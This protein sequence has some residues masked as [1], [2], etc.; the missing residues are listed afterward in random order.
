MAPRFQEKQVI[1]GVGFGGGEV[2]GALAD[3]LSS[4]R[5]PLVQMGR[6]QT[7]RQA[8]ADA[9]ES[10]ITGD[11]T[12]REGTSLSS[13]TYNAIVLAGSVASTSNSV[14]KRLKELEIEHPSDPASYEAKAQAFIKE[15]LTQSDPSI[16]GGLALDF[17]AD[18]INGYSRVLKSHKAETKAAAMAEL[19]TAAGNA[20]NTASSAAF[21]GNSATVAY[22]REKVLTLASRLRSSGEGGKADALIGNFDSNIQKQEVYG[23]Y[24]KAME[25]GSGKAF[26]EEFIRRGKYPPEIKEKYVTEM[27]QRQ[28]RWD[29]LTKE[30]DNQYDSLIMVQGAIDGKMVLDPTDKGHQKAVDTHWQSYAQ[31]LP[32]DPVSA[33]EASSAYITSIGIIP[34][35]IKNL[36]RGAENTQDPKFASMASDIVARINQK[37]PQ[38]L[39]GL[40]NKLPFLLSMNKYKQTGLSVDESFTMA[41]EMTNPDKRAT[42]DFRIEEAKQT[43]EEHELWITESF[44]TVFSFEKDLDPEQKATALQRYGDLYDYWYA[45]TGDEDIAKEQSLNDFAQ[46]YGPT[47]FNDGVVM[48]YPPENYY[49]YDD[50]EW[51]YDQFKSE[52][53]KN[54]ILGV[55]SVTENEAKNMRPS[56]PVLERGEDGILRPL[57]KE[58][59]AGAVQMRWRPDNSEAKAKNNQDAMEN[60]VSKREWQLKSGMREQIRDDFR[61]SMEPAEFSGVARGGVQAFEETGRLI[62][63]EP[64]P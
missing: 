19:N 23:T 5:A 24:Q 37:E 20:I 31:G 29:R 14:N 57:I 8:T 1:T 53:G 61:H 22:E 41:R 15:T 17:E 56:Y 28:S 16:R 21:D 49:S 4:F 43:K 27:S 45:K 54:A 58:T 34:T 36:M 32:D 46:S 7:T 39:G 51:M 38:M 40:K 62:Q 11:F 59:A 55:D 33:L 47:E 63:E 2:A 48:A 30:V 6:E 64:N 9:Q 10:L 42:I 25:E 44:D 3:T 52:A 18:Y 35:P 12:P 60:A 13:N 50:N 26:I